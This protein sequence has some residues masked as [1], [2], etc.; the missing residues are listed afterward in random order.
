[1]ERS[2]QTLFHYHEATKHHYHRYARSAGH[3]DWANQP[4]P[5]RWY[6]GS[7]QIPLPLIGSDADA[8]YMALYRRADAPAR[9]FSL[10]EVAGFLELSMG[11]SAWKSYGGS[12]WALR[13]NP[14]SGNLH[15]TECH[16]VLPEMPGIAAGVYHYNPLDHILEQRALI[17]A[18]T[19]NRVHA[20]FGAKVFLVGLT[21]IYWREAWKYGERAFRYCNLDAGHS[22]AALAVSA[23]LKG[24]RMTAL[25]D[26][27]GEEM[28]RV[29]GLDRVAWHAEEAED[30]EVLCAVQF[31]DRSLPS[32]LPE[33]VIAD[34][35]RLA[36]Q[37]TP[38]PL[39]RRVVPW[40][41]IG[42]AARE[43]RK[44]RTQET[45]T[46]YAGLPFRDTGPVNRT[47]AQIIRT[48]RSA[49]EMDGGGGLDKSRFVSML[50]KTLP[51]KKIAPFDLDIG[52]ARSDLLLFVHEVIGLD[53]G[54]YLFSRTA[55][56]PEDLKRRLDRQWMWEPV[57][58]G[59]P[60]FL[61]DRGDFRRRAMEVSCHQEIAGSGAFSL[62]MLSRFRDTVA[63][64]PHLYR[65]LF[66]EAGM[67]GQVLYLEAEAHGVRG[68][69]IGCFFDDPVH[70]LL[71]LTDAGV[72]SLYHFTVG[73]P[74]E[75]QRMA[76]QPPY[77]HLKRRPGEQTCIPCGPS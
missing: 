34:F 73:K 46:D 77:V 16:L 30:S 37:G 59:F 76:T 42:E 17:P 10:S 63:D 3:M 60:L 23:G 54:L 50:D 49:A 1:M 21:S 35:T 47:A 8:P 55:S 53:P 12:R 6:E 24:W 68:T 44:P 40:D 28:D 67:I 11:L 4:D 19:W 22:L 48:R 18:E 39:S 43:S 65:R 51:R 64:S 26:L 27:S 75:D 57:T 13:I 38:N 2:A 45:P 71:G 62:G 66:W 33:G 36:F 25:R 56:A 15:P 5:F 20:H 31:T 14:S 61:L 70:Q 29:L 74:I 7:V 72:Q 32:G 52:P 58:E 9:P 69:G 41:I